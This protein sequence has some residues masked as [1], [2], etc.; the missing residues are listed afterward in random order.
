MTANNFS[1]FSISTS[2]TAGATTYGQLLKFYFYDISLKRT[3]PH[4][5]NFIHLLVD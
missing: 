5:I 1:N 4:P 3:M 2:V